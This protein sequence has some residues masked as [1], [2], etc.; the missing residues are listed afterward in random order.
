MYYSKPHT[1][2][3]DCIYF[4]NTP[5]EFKQ[6]TSLL[7]LHFTNH[8]FNKSIASTVHKLYGKVNSALYD[9]KNVP[10]NVKSKLLAIYCL[11]L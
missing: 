10:C 1:D 5:I 2:R 9:F 7:G 8:I 11:D 6:S 3:H 4:M